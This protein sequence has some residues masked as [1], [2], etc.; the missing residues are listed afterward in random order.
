MLNKYLFKHYCKRFFSIFFLFFLLAFLL[1]T[2]A[3]FGQL[4]YLNSTSLLISFYSLLQMPELVEKLLPF[5]VFFAALSHFLA[6]NSDYELIILRSSGF[7]IWQ[8]IFPS[9]LFA[10]ILGLFGIFL[11][12]PA[13]FYANEMIKKTFYPQE[14]SKKIISPARQSLWFSQTVN[15]QNLIIG[16]ESFDKKNAV[17]FNTTF[18]FLKANQSI[19]WIDADKAYLKEGYW[20]LPKATSYEFGQPLQKVY[21]KKIE[22]NINSEAFENYLSQNSNILFYKL[23]EKMKMSMFFGIQDY[24]AET[25]FYS[26]L[27]SP[28]LLLTMVCLA[29]L[30]SMNFSRYGQKRFLIVAGLFISFSTYVITILV[31]NLGIHGFISPMLAG[32]FPFLLIFSMA[33]FFLLHREES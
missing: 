25:N 15:H 5:I 7:S 11:L 16:S 17:L 9:C 12:N 31:K 4:S 20:L 23:P 24:E 3:R 1:N 29:A 27:A 19:L 10:F 22:T 2:S 8:I 13:S 32:F 28:F 30:I 33:C 21:N 14:R 18:M 26:L 6:L